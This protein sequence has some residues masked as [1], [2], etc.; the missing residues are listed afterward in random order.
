MIIGFDFDNTIASYEQV[1]FKAAVQRDLISA[2]GPQSKLEIREALRAAGRED[3]WTELQGYVYGPGMS[4]A[5]PFDGVCDAFKALSARGAKLHIISHRTR[6]PFL[7][8]D[9]DLHAFARE[10]IANQDLCNGTGLR[11]GDIFFEETKEAKSA[12][13]GALGCEAFVDDLP[14]ILSADHFPRDTQ[15]FLFDPNGT[16]APGEGVTPVNSWDAL[17]RALLA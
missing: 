11:P 13:I 2:E 9:Y 15:R 4:L 1:F 5:R 6:H 3:E 14:E 17:T 16:H 7:G 10:W 12:R 8:P